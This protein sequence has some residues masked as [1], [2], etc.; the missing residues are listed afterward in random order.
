MPRAVRLGNRNLAALAQVLDR[1]YSWAQIRNLL[2]KFGLQEP[3]SVAAKISMLVDVFTPLTN[4]EADE[5]SVRSVI[6][7]LEEVAQHVKGSEDYDRL[8]S[9]L[10]VDG[11]DLVDRRVT[12]FL[13]PSVLPAE[14]QGLLEARLAPPAFAVARSHLAQ[15]IDN[16]ARG[17][18]EAANSQ[19]RSF[20]EGLCDSIA[21]NVYQGGGNAPTGG[22]ARKHLA[23]IGFL[24]DKESALLR[25]FGEVLHGAG[26]H[27][28]TSDEADCHRRRLMAVAM[29]NYHLDRLE[30]WQ[31]A[32]GTQ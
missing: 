21:A 20:I 25:A 27:A 11:L 26:S 24:D 14:E 1:T 3:S 17:N 8:Q 10:R 23:E 4:A 12:A 13:S 29:G 22:A 15:A 6:D 2:F 9:A 30:E 28:G 19:V 32:Q 16:A 5:H 7:L 18:W 31:R